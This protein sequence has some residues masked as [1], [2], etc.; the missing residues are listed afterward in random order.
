MRVL[1]NKSYQGKKAWLRKAATVILIMMLC[2]F[3]AYPVTT[4]AQEATEAGQEQKVIRVGYYIAPGFQDYDEKTQTYSGC[5][6]EYL[7]AIQQ[8]TGWKY[9]FV[10]VEFAEG[11][12]M[13][14]N[15]ELD[16]M[17]NVSKTSYREQ[18]LGFSDYASGT[19]YGCI[20]V[21]QDN[22]DY[23]YNDYES[24]QNMK[25][26]ILSTSIFRG[27]FDDFCKEHDLHPQ[28]FYFDTGDEMTQA[29]K[30]GIIDARVVSSSYGDGSRIVAEFA[31]MDYYFAVPKDEEDVLEELN[32]AMTRIK[33]D[34]PNF[35]QEM[36]RHYQ[37]R[38]E[39]QTVVLSSQ[40]KEFLK[41]NSVIT[42]AV[43]GSWYPMI[44]FD[45][46]GNC[47]GSLV[48]IYD[49]ISE[50]TGL[51]FRFVA[52]PSY[53]DAL[54][55]IK[56]GETDMI[57]DFPYDFV[58]ANQWNVEL[59]DVVNE[60][61]V[62]RVVNENHNSSDIK[63]IAVYGQPYL[64]KQ[65]YKIYGDTVSYDEYDNAEDALEAVLD[66]KADC[67]FMNY[68]T[69]TAFQ[70]RG[71]YISLKYI[72][73]PSMQYQLGL[74][75]SN[76][77]DGCLKSII[78]KGIQ[79]ISDEDIDAIFQGAANTS[80]ALDFETLFYEKPQV[81]IV[82][83]ALFIA[84][85]GVCLVVLFYSSRMKKKNIEL[86]RAKTAQSSFLS[87]M[88]HDM[89]TPMNVIL[90]LSYLME[91]E[92]N[93]DTLK[94]YIPQLQESSEFLL[95]L[96]NDVLDVNK[97]ESGNLTIN[98]H[99]CDEKGVFDSIINMMQP[100]IAEKHLEFH[101]EKKEPEWYQMMI[102]EQR[103]KQIFINLLNNAVKF[104][105]QGGKIEFIMERVEQTD[106]MIRN[107]FIVRDTGIGIS[108]DFL[109]HI[110]EPFKQENTNEDYTMGT[111]LGLPIAKQ[112]IEMMGGTISISS[113]KGCGTTITLFLNMPLVKK[114][115]E[116]ISITPAPKAA[117]RTE[118]PEVLRPGFQILLCEDHP[119]N[120]K[121]ATKL[122]EQQKA[123]VT[124]AKDGKEGVTL[125]QQSKPGTYDVILMDI[126]MP[127]MDGLEATRRIRAL[128]RE[129]ATQIPIIAMS[130]NAY[131]ED[132][133]KS[134]EA[135]M[136][137]HLAKPIEPRKIYEQIQFY[138]RDIKKNHAG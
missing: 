67:T 49:R 123:V 79:S 48:D 107:K 6:Y 3:F 64:E 29:L 15:G 93:M 77:T 30:N 21:D 117:K 53:T 127:E 74:G 57:V 85:I 60:M 32:D 102:D 51:Q 136:N 111:G 98:P 125:F 22:T 11:V 23:A 73:I 113:K 33:I 58:F 43:G 47:S 56:S 40:E 25:V 5:S 116:E 71:K 103:V 16:L 65:I 118:P 134:L 63:R 129:D 128:D 44:S 114:K 68:F 86:E 106:E 17:N 96:I 130:A 36:E 97:I 19:N 66:G 75:M 91:K 82:V 80:P 62:Y 101:F 52:Y 10:P 42:V 104:T 133:K 126:R 78:G 137:A 41:E 9:E 61:N 59:S 35:Q 84:A 13:L 27:Y 4:M 119:L 81:F 87:R 138:T 39:E 105:P 14:E 94:G 45:E 18:T 135:G 70:N 2:S 99:E 132:V 90:G 7:M 1:K 55:A 122:L 24:F 124:W 131:E 72:L 115:K 69:S 31:P 26:G 110:L 28:I 54:N 120:A 108:K 112:L 46:K 100:L 20:L 50:A 121:I 83:I 8:Y 76:K 92:Q 88:S 109:P 12:E 89:R 95:Q 38:Q 34:M 37:S